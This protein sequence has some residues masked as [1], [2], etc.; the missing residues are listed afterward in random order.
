M[1]KLIPYTTI[2]DFFEHECGSKVWP[3]DDPE[4][5]PFDK[6][7]CKKCGALFVLQM[8]GSRMIGELTFEVEALQQLRDHIIAAHIQIENQERLKSC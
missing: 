5:S 2:W 4:D 1:T 8:Y 7:T 6:Y 3:S